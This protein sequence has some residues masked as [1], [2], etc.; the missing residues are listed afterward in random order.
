MRGGERGFSLAETA[1]ALFVGLLVSAAVLALLDTVQKAE[2]R[3][4][5]D[6]HRAA[7]LRL[8]A[9]R[10]CRAVRHAGTGSRAA[11]APF[12]PLEAAQADTLTLLADLDGD[13]VPAGAGERVTFRLDDEGVF[14]ESGRPVAEG[15][16]QFSLSYLVAAGVD[17]LRD[18]ADNDGD[19]L[20]DQRGELRVTDE[21]LS[22][23][24]DGRDNDGDGVVDE[25]DES[26]LWHVR[27]VQA[28]LAGRG[29][30]GEAPGA[31]AGREVRAAAAL[32]AGN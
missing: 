10:L 8:A 3:F 11:P 26:E 20:V 1:V 7:A 15:L 27:V 17:G 6:A 4:R 16:T 24:G 12:P 25:A 2:L 18:W 29:P 23:S 5:A 13:G 14:R 22:R 30:L 21:P 32:P 9:R 31:A 28:T 19:G